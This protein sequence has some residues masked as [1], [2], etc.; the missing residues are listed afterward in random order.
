MT[1][2]PSPNSRFSVY[3]DTGGQGEDMNLGLTA[4][5]YSVVDLS[6]IKMC[7]TSST[8]TE[9]GRH[10]QSTLAFT[11]RKRYKEALVGGTTVSALNNTRQ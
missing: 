11:V 4:S 7:V 5:Q 8:I 10:P 2:R 9:G 6:K 1:H 3:T